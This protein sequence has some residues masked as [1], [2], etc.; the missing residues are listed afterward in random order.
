MSNLVVRT[1]KKEWDAYRANI[2]HMLHGNCATHVADGNYNLWMVIRRFIMLLDRR[3]VAGKLILKV[4]QI[5]WVF[6]IRLWLLFSIKTY[7]K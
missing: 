6:T 5:G 4:Q 3:C 7:Q 2:G 1:G